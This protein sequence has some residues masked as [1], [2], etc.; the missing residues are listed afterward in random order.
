[1][2]KEKAFNKKFLCVVNNSQA[3]VVFTC[4]SVYTEKLLVFSQH[5]SDVIWKIKNSQ[6]YHCE[7]AALKLNLKVKFLCWA[8][9]KYIKTAETKTEKVPGDFQPY[10]YDQWNTAYCLGYVIIRH[11]NLLISTSKEH[12]TEERKCF[13][14][15]SST[16]VFIQC[17]QEFV[18]LLSSWLCTKLW[19]IQKCHSY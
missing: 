5:C 14:D 3:V 12:L 11:L 4:Q 17:F 7:M 18:C 2:E 16:S 13:C 10:T 8:L 1:M 19:K 15:R 9:T 6:H